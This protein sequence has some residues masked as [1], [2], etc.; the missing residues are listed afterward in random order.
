MAF[1]FIGKNRSNDRPINRKQAIYTQMYNKNNNGI[2]WK[3]VT[4]VDVEANVTTGTIAVGNLFN[5][6]R[7]FF[8][9]C[10]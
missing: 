2:A 5:T 10:N 7:T 3:N 9:I 1:L 8:R 6:P 4:I